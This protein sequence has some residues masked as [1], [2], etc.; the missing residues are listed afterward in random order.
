MEVLDHRYCPVYRWYD[1]LLK[2]ATRNRHLEFLRLPLIVNKVC[3]DVAAWPCRQFDLCL[4]RL[5][6]EDVPE[7][8]VR[9]GRVAKILDPLDLKVLAEIWND[10]LPHKQFIEIAATKEIVSLMVDNAD[11]S[12]LN[13]Q[14]R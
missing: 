4:F 1:E 13:A 12:M 9:A 8:I 11:F 5:V 14:E 3:I 7:D 6:G 10:D 2:L